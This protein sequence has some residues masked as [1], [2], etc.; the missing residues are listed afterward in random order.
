MKP[1]PDLDDIDCDRR[2]NRVS[3]HRDLRSL[4]GRSHVLDPSPISAATLANTIALLDAE[5]LNKI[6]HAIVQLGH[7]TV[8]HSM[9]A[10]LQARGDS[11]VVETDVEYPTDLRLLW[12]AI[13]AAIQQ[14][15]RLCKLLGVAGWRQA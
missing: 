6:N 10:G 9:D 5:V 13:R 3:N 4:A 7:K 11:F 2:T 1:G 8:G 14:P 12:D 15:V